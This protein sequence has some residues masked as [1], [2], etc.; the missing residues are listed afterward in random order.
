MLLLFSA[1]QHRKGGSDTDTTT[2]T[3]HVKPVFEGAFERSMVNI[4]TNPMYNIFGESNEAKLAKLCQKDTQLKDTIQTFT[5]DIFKNNSAAS[6]SDREEIFKR[7][8]NLRTN[9]DVL[10]KFFGVIDIIVSKKYSR[11]DI[12]NFN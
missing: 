7:F 5:Q 8:H 1:H 2:L 3:D 4:M 6:S 12:I 9:E 11:E 10:M